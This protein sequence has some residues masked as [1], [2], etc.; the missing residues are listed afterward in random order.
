[1]EEISAEERVKQLAE[2]VSELRDVLLFT[3]E[4]HFDALVAI[5]RVLIESDDSFAERFRAAFIARAFHD[6]GWTPPEHPKEANRLL[7]ALGLEQVR[8]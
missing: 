5:A 8:R 3:G 1:M 4:A 2:T 7:A 6:A